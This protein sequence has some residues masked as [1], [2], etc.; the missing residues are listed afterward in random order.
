MVRLEYLTADIGRFHIQL[1]IV[2]IETLLGYFLQ[3]VESLFT[4][5][6]FMSAGL[7]HTAHPFQFCTIQVVGADDLDIRCINAFLPFLQ[8][9]TI[10][11]FVLI[12]LTIVYFNDFGAD[13]IQK[14]AVVRHHKQ[15][16]VGAAQ[17]IFQPFSHIK[18]EV[19]GRLIQNQKIRFSDKGIGKCHT[20]QLTTGKVLYLL[21]EITYLQLRQNLL[22][23]LLIV[24]CFF[25]VHAYQDFIESRMPFR[26]H[27]TFVFLNQFYSTVAMMKTGFQYSQVF[28]ILRVL[29]QIPHPEVTAERYIPTVISLF[30][31]NDIQ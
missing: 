6:G 29:F 7:R 21:V 31:G 2:V 15:A 9:I 13:T 4:I 18:I 24:P 11:S 22:G 25:M 12:N 1:H 3:F 17:I 30:S 10:V 8:I 5:A 26:L 20:L 28:R 23:L 19:V 14:I 27:A 16:E